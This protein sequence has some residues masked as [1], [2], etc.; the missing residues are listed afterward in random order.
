MST[1]VSHLALSIARRILAKS[2][3]GGVKGARDTRV[4]SSASSVVVPLKVG[5]AV[6]DAELVLSEIVITELDCGAVVAASA[7]VA[8]ATVASAVERAIASAK[9]SMTP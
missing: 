5:S 6:V 8:S 9:R 7:V 2:M 4:V 1:I 3:V